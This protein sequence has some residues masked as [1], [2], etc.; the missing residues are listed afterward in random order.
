VLF[1]DD[2]QLGDD[3]TASVFTE[4]FKQ[5]DAPEALFVATYRSEDAATNRCLRQI[6]RSQLPLVE[7][8]R[9]T[10][11]VEISIDKLTEP[12]STRLASSLLL[13]ASIQEMDEVKRI[14]SEAQGDPL[15]I[16]MLADYRI[17]KHEILRAESPGVTTKPKR[18]TLATV[19]K[20][21]VRTLEPHE[22][23][24][25]E[26]LSVAGRP[27]DANDLESVA[28]VTGQSIALIRSLRIKRLVR[29]LS[30][31]ERIEIFHDKIRETVLT[32]LDPSQIAGH[33]LA[34]AKQIELA[35]AERDVDFLAD[36]YRRGGER[37]LAGECYEIAAAKSEQTYA[38]NR[39]IECYRFAIELLQPKGAHELRLRRGLGD[40]LANASR[41]AEAAEQYL[42]A[43]AVAGTGEATQ[44]TQLA[45]LRYL[46]SGHVEQ[47]I[48]SLRKSLDDNSIAWPGNRIV[49]VAGLVQRTA[50]L[51]LRGFKMSGKR[52]P[53]ELDN[54]KIDACWSAAAGLSLV[55]PLRGSYY[56][57]ETLC[58]SLRAGSAHTIAR[59][60]AAYMGVVAIGGSRSRPATARVLRACRNVTLSH[61]DHYSRA[62]QHL[63]QGMAALL[64]GHWTAS[65]RSCDRAIAYLSD[66]SCHGKTWELNTARTFALWSLQYQ[67][68]LIEL[69]RRQPELLRWAKESD[70]LFATL[71]FGTQVMAHL[72]LAENKPEESLRRL[73]E[74]KSRLSNRGFF[75]QHHNYV[76]AQTYSLLY[77]GDYSGALQAIDGQW[78]QYRR[79]F[80]SQIQQVRIDHRQVLIR[81][82][83]ANAAYDATVRAE[84][85]SEAKQLIQ[86]LRRERVEWAGALADALDASWF[87]IA[88]H[89]KQAAVMLATAH[90]SLEKVGMR[91]FA[92]AALHHLDRGTERSEQTHGMNGISTNDMTEQWRAMGIVAGDRFAN[93]L[94]P[95]FG[96]ELQNDAQ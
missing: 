16:R 94:I 88:G 2:L 12:E 44:L 73:A 78:K 13:R 24:A 51:R 91:L 56:I 68:N 59:D 50:Y 29:R 8:N 39:A 1:V 60:L 27:V 80:L 58:R 81:A 42:K 90:R 82:I 38:F 30:D 21:Q 93:M 52:S 19:I 86:S 14:V 70:D 72:Q 3:D 7:A 31:R 62:M 79:E 74:D 85:L 69:S 96:K 25:I 54:Q 10:E 6:R 15:F 43:A 20:Q 67:G 37:K 45:S 18:W 48:V 84:R 34:I 53:T 9:L 63:T 40:S 47:G 71:N 22:R 17:R 46:T 33:C 55:D 4:L 95:G 64:R 89:S 83:L 49:A 26:I 61:R 23:T 41:S 32:M 66:P 65:L 36:L 92:T 35:T 57:A 87:C 5:D 75:I 76:L 77:L 11:Q 28:S